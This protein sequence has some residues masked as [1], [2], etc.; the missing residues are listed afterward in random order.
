MPENTRRMKMIN[1]I[2]RL[3]SEIKPETLKAYAESKGWDYRHTLRRHRRYGHVGH[4]YLFVLPLRSGSRFMSK[5]AG[6]FS[7]HEDRPI[8]AIL[9]DLWRMQNPSAS[10]LDWLQ[11][12][13]K[14]NGIKR[15]YEFLI[16]L[17]SEYKDNINEEGLRIRVACLQSDLFYSRESSKIESEKKDKLIADLDA[18]VKRL[19]A[20]P[21]IRSDL[22]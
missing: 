21:K 10:E 19:N 14:T 9:F 16:Y 20:E 3:C 2:E 22:L 11:E 7:E 4:E 12:H 1:E 18:E 6:H 5:A 13:L 17:C 15:L 8:L